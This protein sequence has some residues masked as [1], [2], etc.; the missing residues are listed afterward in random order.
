MENA[1]TGQRK[2]REREREREREFAHEKFQ[3][4]LIGHTHTHTHTM[5][6]SADDRAA[7][8]SKAEDAMAAMTSQWKDKWKE[9]T[10]LLEKRALR[11]KET[12][13]ALKVTYQPNAH[14]KLLEMA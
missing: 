11:V 5:R 12:G 8:V 13:R 9:Q 3:K 14:T 2:K 10:D 1:R 7:A 4:L 6:Q